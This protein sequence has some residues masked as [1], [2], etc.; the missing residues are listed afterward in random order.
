MHRDIGSQ[1]ELAFT[2]GGLFAR[3]ASLLAPKYLELQDWSE[4]RILA[5]EDN[6]LQTRTRSTSVR[7][8]RETVKRL[9]VL[10]P[11]EIEPPASASPR[12]S[13]R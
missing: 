12:W 10:T 1:Y 9:A 2:T 4:V 3:E 11:C 5:V 7:H 13:H 8:V 6:L